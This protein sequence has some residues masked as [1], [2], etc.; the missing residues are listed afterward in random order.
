MVV[1]LSVVCLTVCSSA[2]H[3]TIVKYGYTTS[4]LYEVGNNVFN[5]IPMVLVLGLSFFKCFPIQMGMPLYYSTQR[6]FSSQNYN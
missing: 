1:K 2:C 4:L 5:E 6:E 3:Q